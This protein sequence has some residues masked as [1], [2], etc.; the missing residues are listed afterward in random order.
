M[1]PSNWKWKNTCVFS[2]KRICRRGRHWFA[3]HLSNLSRAPYYISPRWIDISFFTIISK[4][5]NWLRTPFEVPEL[6]VDC[7]VDCIVEQQ[8]KLL[9]R[10][11]SQFCV[12]VQTREPNLWS[13]PAGNKSSI[14]PTIAHT[15]FF[16]CEA[17]FQRYNYFK[18]M[19]R[20][21]FQREDDTMCALNT[22]SPYF[23]QL[24]RQ[25]RGKILIEFC[26]CG[27]GLPQKFFQGGQSRHFA[28]LFQ[29]VGNAMQM[30]VYKKMSSVT[31]TV[32]Y[33]VFLE[34]SFTLSKCLF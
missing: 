8:I 1:D 31:T 25:L 15:V 20:Y 30:D 34:R 4:I 5:L 21:R 26:G 9:S 3:L 29:A 23:N 6:Q 18:T 16:R 28:Y 33:M 22:T 24:V 27:H 13:V 19:H 11:L 12:D 10:Q 2:I 14:F 7:E 32:A 17:V